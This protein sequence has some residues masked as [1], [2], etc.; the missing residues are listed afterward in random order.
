LHENVSIAIVAAGSF[1]YRAD[2]AGV[3]MTPGSLLLGNSG[4]CF[5]CRHEHGAGDRCI[6]FHFTPAYFEELAAAAGVRGGRADFRTTRL[7]PLRAS[8]P[9]IAAACAGLNGSADLLWEELAQRLAAHALQTAGDLSPQEKPVPAAVFARVTELVRVIEENPAAEFTLGDLARVA[10][11]SPYHF[12]RLF[13]Q[14]TGTTPHQFLLRARLRGAALRLV[15]EPAKILDIALDGG[16]GDV[17]N[18]NRAFRA[19]FGKSPRAYRI[20]SAIKN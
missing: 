20:S 16:F 1:V 17:S 12:L 18:F 5:E 10:G 7:P 2:S 6:S 9:L 8:A 11:L 14:A 4:Q 15:Q 3:L 19:E 13:E